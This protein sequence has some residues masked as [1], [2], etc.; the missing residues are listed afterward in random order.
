M[1]GM[2]LLVAMIGS[3]TLTLAEMKG[4]KTQNIYKQL[5]Q[6]FKQSVRLKVEKNT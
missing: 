5:K 2:I 3:I 4:P 1:A 6:D